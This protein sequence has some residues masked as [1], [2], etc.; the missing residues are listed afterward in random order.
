MKKTMFVLAALCLSMSAGALLPDEENTIKVFKDASP[1][2]VFVTNIAVGQDAFADEYA[3]PRGAGS[4]FIWDEQ[5]HI[6]T[7]F[8]VVNGGNAFL[9]TLK[10]GT[11]L[12]ARLVGLE[13]RKDIAVLQVTKNLEKMRPIA[14]GS[15]ETLQVGQ[16][17]I[18]IGNPFGLDNTM[19]TGIISALGRQ[20]EGIGGVTIKDVIQTDAAINP[21]NS[22]GPLLDSDGK[23]IGMNT[24]IYS[25]SGSSAGV[26]F[27]VPVSFIKRIVP[28]IIKY[29]KTIQPGIG[30]SILTPDQNKQILGRIPGV[31]VRDV[32]PNTPA[33][34]AGLL[35]IRR[36]RATGRLMLGDIIVGIDGVQIKD[37]DDLY[38]SLDLHKVGDTVTLNTVRDGQKSSYRLELINVF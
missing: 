4:G 22:G 2:V 37:Y 10:D 6:V 1:A 8:H 5:G 28:Q 25:N 17:A 9:V 30:V 34:R 23:L 38:N 15:S 21:G 3:V 24:M 33:A 18:A 13:P 35:G 19:T 29:G 32:S 12:E 36:S 11:E 16:K 7:N 27:A 31:V 26:G 20:I 14:V